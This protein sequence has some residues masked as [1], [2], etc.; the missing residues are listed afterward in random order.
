MSFLGTLDISASGLT[1]QRL[2][3][4]TIASNLANV[5]T[6]RSADGTGAYRRQVVLMQAVPSEARPF[7]SYLRQQVGAAGKKIAP[8]GST[9]V[10]MELPAETSSRLILSGTAKVRVLAHTATAAREVGQGVRVTELR[11]LTEEEAPLRRVYEPAHPDADAEGYV[12]Y[13]NVNVIEE[14]VNM[15]SANRS[16]DANSKVIESTKA[17]T[18]RALELG[19]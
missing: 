8:P 6:T 2:R 15:I 14:M 10:R 1:A 7:S 19:R 4:D 12:T 9:N 17:M 18:I 5:E 13:P 3:L 11:S 16:Y